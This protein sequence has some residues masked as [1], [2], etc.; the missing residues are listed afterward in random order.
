LAELPGVQS[1][2]RLLGLDE[3]SSLVSVVAGLPHGEDHDE[4][5]QEA[6]IGLLEAIDRFDNGAAFVPRPMPPPASEAS[7]RALS[8]G[9]T[10]TPTS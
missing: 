3:P 5:L 10:G 4:L 2:P 6:R 7:S 8:C 9:A 1:R